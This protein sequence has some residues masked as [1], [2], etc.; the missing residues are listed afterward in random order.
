M[1]GIEGSIRRIRRRPDDLWR[2]TG[3]PHEVARAKV[4]AGR[5]S[6]FK[7]FLSDRLQV[8][9]QIIPMTL[10]PSINV[11]QDSSSLRKGS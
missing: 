3:L 5:K 6:V 4:Q 10:L 9:K 2:D 1:I 7:S 11:E 8:G